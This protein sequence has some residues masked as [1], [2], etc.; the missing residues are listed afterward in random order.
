[1][2]AIPLLHFVTEP[3]RHAILARLLQGEC[4]VSE[5]VAATGREQSNVSH[6]LRFLRD[7]GMV[8]SRRQGRQQRYRVADSRMK[9]I[10]TRIGRLAIHLERTAY[11][12]GLDLPGDTRYHGYG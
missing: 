1:M 8:A 3:T 7:R 4:T 5:L 12:A 9:E 11:Y 6:H 10:M 2:D